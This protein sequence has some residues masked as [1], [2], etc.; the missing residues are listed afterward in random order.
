[1]PPRKISE[2]REAGARRAT[3]PWGR[4]LARADAK[5]PSLGAELGSSAA[6]AGGVG[7]GFSGLKRDLAGLLEET[8]ELDP[9][10]LDGS[11]LEPTGF[12][13]QSSSPSIG[14]SCLG[15]GVGS[16]VIQVRG[17]NQKDVLGGGLTPGNEL[18]ST[19]PI[20]AGERRGR[21]CE[22]EGGDEGQDRENT[23]GLLP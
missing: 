3:A 14:L 16:T 8:S 22:K 1:M 5:I 23:H 12:A 7:L 17:S 13:V 15:I 2:R 9:F 20:A 10:A 19:F 11:L 18:D 4:D 6:G 21:R